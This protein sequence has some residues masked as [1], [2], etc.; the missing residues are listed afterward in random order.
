MHQEALTCLCQ[1]WL[2]MGFMGFMWLW[3]ADEAVYVCVCK[4]T[5]DLLIPVHHEPADAHVIKIGSRTSGNHD[6]DHAHLQRRC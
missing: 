5:F 1:T 3:S 2:A 6:R 4:F